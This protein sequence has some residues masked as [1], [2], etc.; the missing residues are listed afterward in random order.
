MRY[1]L[2]GFA[3]LSAALMSFCV[4]TVEAQKKKTDTPA[5]AATGEIEIHKTDKGKWRYKVLGADGKTIAM[6]LPQM[7]WDTK[8]EC[9]KAIADLKSILNTAKPTETVEKK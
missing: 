5:A 8:E 9:L 2:L 7:H 4:G 3:V 6:P 1:R